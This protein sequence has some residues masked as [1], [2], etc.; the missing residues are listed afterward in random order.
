M[1]YIDNFF[2]GNEV[3]K[4]GDYRKNKLDPLLK[5][6][7][8]MK[9]E[10]MILK[11]FM[12]EKKICDFGCGDGQFLKKTQKLTRYS[13]GIE[14]QDDYVSEL[15]KEV[16]I[17]KDLSEI[18]KKIDCFFLFHSFEHLID[19]ENVLEQ[20]KKISNDGKIIIEV[21]HANDVLITLYKS[22]EFLNFTLWSQHLILHTRESLRKILEGT[23]FK[24]LL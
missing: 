4:S 13:C 12:L 8:I 19:P 15:K 20:I 11:N 10:Q 16:D 9:E 24:M 1:I 21:P 3:Y 18:K 6:F 7:R 17:Y 14:I 22:I 2:V 5:D 23:G